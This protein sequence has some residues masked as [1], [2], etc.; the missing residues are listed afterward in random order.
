M[1][2]KIHIY[3]KC[4]IVHMAQLDLLLGYNSR[5]LLLNIFLSI[6]KPQCVQQYNNSTQL[7][8]YKLLYE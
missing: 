5:S 1:Q 7:H 8:E 4:L 6:Q 3:V 2:Y